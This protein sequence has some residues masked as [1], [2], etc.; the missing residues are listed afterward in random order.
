MEPS[1]IRARILSDHESLRSDLERLETL[2]A[3][4]REGRSPC[5]ALRVEAESLLAGLR[6]HM[7]WEESYLVPAL[8]EADAWGVERAQR[9]LRDHGEQR[10]LLDFVGSRLGSDAAPAALVVRDMTHLIAL[11]REDMRQEEDEL[12]DERVL[13]DDVIAIDALTS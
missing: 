7:R 3:D 9:L 10:A 6:N 4:V 5:V 11:L 12:L 8:R 13:R 1:A 2:A